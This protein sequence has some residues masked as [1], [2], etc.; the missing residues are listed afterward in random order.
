MFALL[1]L[2]LLLL[3]YSSVKLSIKF[4]DSDISLLCVHN[5]AV[6]L[7]P[8]KLTESGATRISLGIK[9]MMDQGV[10]NPLIANY[11]AGDAHFSYFEYMFS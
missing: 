6:F 11:L 10:L 3:N 4:D 1:D 2:E 7:K 9:V 5:T 8:I